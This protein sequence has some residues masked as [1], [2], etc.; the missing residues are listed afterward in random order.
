MKTCQSLT[1]E[2][3]SVAKREAAG[4]AVSGLNFVMEQAVA[5]VMDLKAARNEESWD[6]AR[7]SGK[8]AAGFDRE[9]L[10][11]RTLGDEA[12]AGEM[13][14]CFVRDMPRQFRRLRALIAIKQAPEAAAVAHLIKGAAAAVACQ[15]M[16]DQ[17]RIMEELAGS[18]DL[19]PLPDHLMELECRFL[20]VEEA[21]DDASLKDPKRDTDGGET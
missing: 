12:L 9:A 14:D 21:I 8:A 20:E 11:K 10:L 16:S 3:T 2:T 18:G 17:A 7:I 5:G 15:P 19:T 1:G 13:L 6:E 4:N